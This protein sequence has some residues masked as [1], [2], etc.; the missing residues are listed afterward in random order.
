MEEC[1]INLEDALAAAVEAAQKAGA[2]M[3]D[4][5][6]YRRQVSA[7][8]ALEKGKGFDSNDEAVSGGEGEKPSVSQLLDTK[9]KSCST[10]LVTEY[11]RHCDEAIMSILQQYSTTVERQKHK[12]GSESFH[13]SFITEEIHPDMRLTDAPTWIVDPIDG[14]MSFVHGSCDCCVSIGLTIK[15]ETVLA[16]IYCPFIHTTNCE[17][18]GFLSSGLQ[19]GELYTAIRGKGA[20]LNGHPIHVRS[21]ITQE[22]AIANF[23]C[24]MRP[25]LSAAELEES[26]G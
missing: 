2:I 3:W 22:E 12:S 17:L 15:K 8:E 13:F 21:D 7:A 11:D 18:T 10:D 23:G 19:K 6:Q 24:P 5:Y 26:G 9:V 1:D 4:F 16:V 14:T 25:V 20:F